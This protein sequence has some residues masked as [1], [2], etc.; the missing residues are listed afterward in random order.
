MSHSLQPHGLR[1]ASLPY[2]QLLEPA[3]TH[4]HQVGIPSNH[5]ILCHLL[6]LLPSILSSIRVFSSELVLHIRCPK[7]WSFSFS[8]SP[9]SEYLGIISFRTDWFHLL[10]V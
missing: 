5:L 4:V 7:Y 9:S 3:Q 8:I 1:H 6:L 2:H 10:A